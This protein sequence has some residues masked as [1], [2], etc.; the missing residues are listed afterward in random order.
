VALEQRTLQLTN[1]RDAAALREHTLRLHEFN[2]RMHTLAMD[3]HGFHT[4]HGRSV[5]LSDGEINFM[6]ERFAY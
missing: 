3:I 6:A 4:R 5:D 2:Q 1:S